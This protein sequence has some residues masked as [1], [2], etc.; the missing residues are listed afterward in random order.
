MLLILS[1]FLRIYWVHLPCQKCKW[2]EFN[3]QKWIDPERTKSQTRKTIRVLH[4]SNPDGRW[5]WYGRDPYNLTKSRIAPYKN[6]W[7]RLQNYCIFGAD[8]GETP[9]A[10]C[11]KQELH[12]ARIATW[13][14]LKRKTCNFIK[15]GPHTI[16]LKTHG[17]SLLKRFALLQ[18]C[19]GMYSNRIRTAV[20]KINETKTKD[21]LGIH[22][23]NRRVPGNAWTTPLTKESLTYSFLQSNSRI[24]IART[25]PR[26]WSRSSRDIRTR[27]LS[28][29]TWI[30]PKRST[31]SAKNRRIW[32]S[33]WTTPRSSNSAKTLPK[34]DAPIAI[35]TGKSA[36]T[37]AAVDE[38]ENRKELKSS[39]RTTTTSA[40]QE[41]V[42]GY[43]SILGSMEQ[44]LPL[45][46]SR[47]L[48]LDGQRSTSSFMT[49]LH[50]RILHTSQQKQ[51]KFQNSTQWNL[52]LNRDRDKHYI[53]DL[54]LLKRK[55]N[56]NDCTTST[57]QGPSKTTR[58][59][60]AVNK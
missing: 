4:D 29:R 45:Q 41:K 33:T 12:H 27:S 35:P 58:Q 28:C 31:C 40:L 17:E 42:G 56:A 6:T 50:W 52:T 11:H 34:S 2:N 8:L 3:N 47:C 57:W 55:E 18:D 43:A 7:K 39:T 53:D 10:T 60:V 25:R 16:V 44:R 38:L 20:N 36:L 48:I 46:K 5:K 22:V 19:H 9:L 32:S 14:S 13:S 59:F 1:C 54:T 49:E 37:I 51:R 15:H 24:Q 26:S 21:H 23:A 30:R